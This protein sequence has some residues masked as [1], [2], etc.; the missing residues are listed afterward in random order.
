M[1]FKII[2][3]YTILSFII[4]T[5]VG[6][7]FGLWISHDEKI[8]ESPVYH[9]FGYVSGFLASF[10]IYYFLFKVKLER[11]VLHALIIGVLSNMLG[12]LIVYLLVGVTTPIL[13]LYVDVL[14]MFVAIALA[15][16]VCKIREQFGVRA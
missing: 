5:L 4:G 10:C 6:I 9:L 1:N 3:I 12:G 15:L 8:I 13:L 16:Y 7:P 2:A 14:L 11:P